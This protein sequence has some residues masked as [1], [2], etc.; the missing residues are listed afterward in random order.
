MANFLRVGL[1][2]KPGFSELFEDVIV[3]V[4]LRCLTVETAAR[5]LVEQGMYVTVNGKRTGAHS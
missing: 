1:E 2:K 5:F 3:L 4:N